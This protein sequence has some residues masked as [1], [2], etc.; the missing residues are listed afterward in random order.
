[1]VIIS[2]DIIVKII[3]DLFSFDYVICWTSTSLAIFI[4]VNWGKLS[5]LISAYSFIFS[6]TPTNSN[7]K[8]RWTITNISNEWKI[9]RYV[10]CSMFNL[11]VKCLICFDE[12]VNV[13]TALHIIITWNSIKWSQ[14]TN[15]DSTLDCTFAWCMNTL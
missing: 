13:C 6:I 14:W 2:D 9:T 8:M 5:I 1:M 15:V 7:D 4:N 10:Q 3:F 12:S 11:V